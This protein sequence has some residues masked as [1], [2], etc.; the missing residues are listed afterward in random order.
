[1]E[2]TYWG[3]GRVGTHT[4]ACTHACTHT[5]LFCCE[6]IGIGHH[7]SVLETTE[8]VSTNDVLK[9][10]LVVLVKVLLKGLLLCGCSAV[11]RSGQ[12]AQAA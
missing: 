2:V 5:H 12:P 1:M 4:H 9:I 7:L 11:R 10:Q 8:N 3:A 6:P